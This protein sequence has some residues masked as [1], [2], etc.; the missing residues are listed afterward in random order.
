MF[1][2]FWFWVDLENGCIF[3]EFLFGSDDF[4]MDLCGQSAFYLSFGFA[5]FDGVT[6]RNVVESVFSAF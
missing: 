4:F 3:F 6:I 5:S 2:L 1:V